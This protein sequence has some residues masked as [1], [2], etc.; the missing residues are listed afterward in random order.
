MIH[1]EE[2]KDAKFLKGA[3]GGGFLSSL[4]SSRFRFILHPS[5]FILL[6]PAVLFLAIFFFLP[7][8]RILSLSL[9]LS[10]L[11]AANLERAFSVFRFTFYQAALSTLLTFLLGLPSAILF[12]RFDFRGKSLLRAITAVP[13][14][15]PTVVVAAGFNALLGPRGWVNIAL[16]SLLRNTQYAT[17]AEFQFTNTLYAIL[18]AHVFYNTTIVIR[19]VGNALTHLDPKL[20]Q[21]ARILGADNWRTW[22]QVTLPLLRAPMLA[23]GLLVFLFDFTSFGVVLLLGGPRYATLE[24]EIYIQAL[25]M[26][27]LPLAGL[28]SLVQLGCTLAFAALYARFQRSARDVPLS[29]R[30]RG[31]GLRVPRGA[32]ERLLV[33][34]VALA[35]ALLILA[36]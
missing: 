15:L 5:S 16:G 22:T 1:R 10:V 23:A 34:G 7:L 27:N 30:V 29:P 26:L 17:L 28:L 20:E 18:L 33:G 6:F 35:L 3:E 19:I 9:D 12:A 21:A 14:M 32:G 24:V 4:R 2:A 36:P 11:T 13:F 31:E 8:A 25:H